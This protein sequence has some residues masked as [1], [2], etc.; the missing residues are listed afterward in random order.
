ML[1]EI[2]VVLDAS[3]NRTTMA[4]VYTVNE[5]SVQGDNGGLSCENVPRGSKLV[6]SPLVVKP[7]KIKAEYSTTTSAEE[8]HGG[9]TDPEQVSRHHATGDDALVEIKEERNDDE[10]YFQIKLGDIGGNSDERVQNNESDQ[11]EQD[12]ESAA[13]GD[14]LFRCVDCG[15][16]FGQREA[17]LEHRREHTHDGPIVCLD[18][19]SQW[20]DLL[21]SEDGGRRTLCCALCGRKF[22]SSRGFFAHQ[23]K[24]RSEDIKQEPESEVAISVRKQHIFECKDCGKKYSALGYYLNHQRSHKQA[25]KS[26]FHQLAQLKKKS[27]QCS[28]CGRCYSRASALDAHHRCHEV[29]LVKS[30]SSGMEK[31]PT[32]Q[33]VAE[34]NGDKVGYYK[35][36]VLLHK[37]SD[38]GK[39][40]RS[41][42]GLG[43][44]QR[45]RSNCKGEFKQSFHCPECDK[46]FLSSNAL[47]GHQQWHIRRISSGMSLTCK[48]CGKV[49]SSLTFYQRHQRVAHSAPAKSFLHQVCQLQ[50]KSFECQDCGRR[51]SRASALQSHRLCHTN[52][53]GDLPERVSQKPVS[54]E[55]LLSASQKLYL[56]DKEKPESF[57]IGTLVYTQGTSQTLDITEGFSCKEADEVTKGDNIGLGVESVNV[58]GSDNSVA[59]NAPLLVS[60]AE[61]QTSTMCDP[62]NKDDVT[63]PLNQ[64]AGSGSSEVDVELEFEPVESRENYNPPSKRR[65]SDC[66]ECGR[67]FASANAMRCH[68]LWHKRPM[69]RAAGHKIWTHKIPSQTYLKKL[70]KCNDCGQESSTLTSHHQHLQQHENPKPQKSL[71]QLGGLKNSF[72]CEECGMCFSRAS[73]LHSHQQH[74]VQ[75]KRIHKCSLC[76]KAYSS[77]S[78]L[79]SHQRAC[80]AAAL[81]RKD[82]F[83]PRKTLLGPKLYYCEKCGKG[84]WSLGAFSQHKQQQCAEVQGKT[85]T[86]EP[87]ASNNSRSRASC[88]R[89]VC[90][91]CGKKFRH[92]GYLAC[93]MKRHNSTPKKNHKCE[94]C[95]KSYSI[96]SCF[97]KHQQ[98][99]DS[100][101][102]KPAVKSFQDEVEQVKKN[103]YSCPH[104]DKLFSRAMALQ[105]HMRSHG[106]ETGYPFSLSKSLP[107]ADLFN[108]PT[109]P[110]H[111]SSY[112]VLQD[113]M[114][115]KH[116]GNK[117]KVNEGTIEDKKQKSLGKPVKSLSKGNKNLQSKTDNCTKTTKASQLLLKSLHSPVKSES[118]KYKCSE[119]GKG[120]SV[121]G[122][123]NFHKRIHL[124]YQITSD[125]G[126]PFPAVE[127]PKYQKDGSDIN[128]Q[129]VCP[130]CG[131]SFNTD[132]ALGTH[133]CCHT[134]K[135]FSSTLSI[136]DVDKSKSVD[137]GPFH[138]NQCG[139][140]FFYYCVL[141]RHQMHHYGYETQGKPESRSDSTQESDKPSTSRLACPK[142]DKTFNRASLLA[143]HYHS[144][145][146]KTAICSQ[147]SVP[148]SSTEALQKH[149][150]QVHCNLGLCNQSDVQGPV[151]SKG[152]VQKNKCYKCPDCSK[153]FFKIRGLRAHRWKMHHGSK[154]ALGAFKTSLKP[155]PCTGCEKRYSSQGAL[156]NHRKICVVAKKKLKRQK[157][158]KDPLPPRCFSE[159][160]S[161]CL[162]KCHKC[163]KAF[164]TLDRLAAH[165]DIAKS[166]PYCCALCCRGYWTETQLQ[167]H[168]GWHDE[169]RRRLP[170]NLRYR[171]STCA[172]TTVAMSNPVDVASVN[173]GV[174]PLLLKSPAT[175]L[176]GS[177]SKQ[178]KCPHCGDTF[179]TTLALRQHQTLH[180]KQ[181]QYKCGLSPQV[182]SQI[183]DLAD[184]HQECRS[185]RGAQSDV[186]KEPTQMELSKESVGLTC[187]ECGITF[188]QEVELHQ[189]YIGHARGEY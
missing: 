158:V 89:A 130:E 173:N 64:S 118:G 103:T 72:E 57:A 63:I 79:Y 119:C 76:E 68:R 176:A 17:Y 141:R 182:F 172:L 6:I 162:F 159:K 110:A 143:S 145:H 37:C 151:K 121:A 97:F 185:K 39:A 131:K 90:P 133:R 48:E 93:H 7:K 38:C 111:F 104:C 85:N 19:D 31:P 16:T 81:F 95:G 74:H 78:G 43:K 69:G 112:A 154:K 25:S 62:E 5:S 183:Q 189:H 40:F 88:K 157:I 144:H 160:V 142:C 75:P 168:L 23:I 149:Q 30:R 147:C 150:S 98:V 34:E 179:Q 80:H 107:S 66:P 70:F 84:F 46:S 52:V 187:I 129:Y 99:H 132:S 117:Q 180:S 87:V 126:L 20:D 77:H 65:S 14:W 138:C 169:V 60:R 41:L 122:A 18:S 186:Q 101:E 32:L 148:F 94:V 152:I 161:K 113:H 105:F 120:F 83:N 178:C 102:F 137:N 61:P 174:N 100:Q 36:S 54:T 58:T 171:L 123:L 82:R 56:C 4:A 164:P 167:Q 55:S 106:Y 181:G 108:C 22:S 27:F 166:R 33:E 125:L 50:K 188:S 155:F 21:V 140:G 71:F 44:H 139:K 124:R 24:H 35:K 2:R 67:K 177:L 45:F 134:E 47:A 153:H 146:D 115:Q 11:E 175:S 92:R 163:G 53:L 91:V 59:G 12:K 3:K 13:D 86:P 15:E 135:E 165:N 28:T 170:A 96:L 26:V 128:N 29:K 1:R 42:S 156:Y 8:A 9:C 73:A 184:H 136:G 116:G 10:E 109:C 127:E 114:S 49:F 51:F